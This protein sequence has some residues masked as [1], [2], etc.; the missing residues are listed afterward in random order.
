MTLEL[1]HNAH[2]TTHMAHDGDA[3]AEAYVFETKCG[4]RFSGM[5]GSRRVAVATTL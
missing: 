1:L 4:V 5:G 3:N 2:S